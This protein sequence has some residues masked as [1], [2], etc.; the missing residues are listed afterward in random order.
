MVAYSWEEVTEAYGREMLATSAS[1]AVKS[2]RTQN[3]KKF[4][5]DMIMSKTLRSE[6]AYQMTEDKAQAIL[7]FTSARREPALSITSQSILSNFPAA[8]TAPPIVLC[9]SEFG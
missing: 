8:S 2:L 9:S 4:V 3:G 7:S 5:K 1:L 6:C